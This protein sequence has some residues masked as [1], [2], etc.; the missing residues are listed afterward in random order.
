M[1]HATHP[2]IK[3]LPSSSV[4]SFSMNEILVLQAWPLDPG[5]GLADIGTLYTLVAGN[6]GFVVRW[7]IRI[8]ILTVVLRCSFSSARSAKCHR[9]QRLAGSY[10]VIYRV[11]SQEG[12]SRVI[13]IWSDRS[14][15]RSYDSLLKTRP[16]RHDLICYVGVTRYHGFLNREFLR[17]SK[18]LLPGDTKYDLANRWRSSINEQRVNSS[19]NSWRLLFFLLFV[20]SLFAPSFTDSIFL[21]DKFYWSSWWFHTGTR[22][23]DSWIILLYRTAFIEFQNE[24]ISQW[25]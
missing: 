25:E 14:I 9:V 8:P 7:T 15:V 22:R 24:W 2:E 23:V 19:I 21:I 13:G 10:D 16:R 17:D 5:E 6:G 18:P 11:S 12:C 20:Y 3:S 1:L 4:I